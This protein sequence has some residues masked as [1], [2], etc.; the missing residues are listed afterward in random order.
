MSRVTKLFPKP[1][2]PANNVSF[3]SGIR[4][5]HSHESFSAGMSLMRC[6][7]AP[8]AAVCFPCIQQ[9]C[10]RNSRSSL[11]PNRDSCEPRS[12]FRLIYARVC[13]CDIENEGLH[14]IEQTLL[15]LGH[16]FIG[17]TSRSFI[18][19]APRRRTTPS[20]L[21]AAGSKPHDGCSGGAAFGEGLKRVSPGSS[22]NQEC[23][24]S[25]T[26]AV[27]VLDP[28]TTV[29][30]AQKPG[31]CTARRMP[32][33]REEVPQDRRPQPSKFQ[34]IRSLLCAEKAVYASRHSRSIRP[35]PQTMFP[36]TLWPTCLVFPR[37]A[38]TLHNR[39]L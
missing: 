23:R 36:Q 8:I 37:Q 25:P 26:S 19:G 39:S 12:D 33:S 17:G 20:R 9:K 1:G 3:P 10:L 27:Q 21:R 18:T 14:E 16:A 4:P 2:S 22:R 32:E 34:V 35:G 13:L 11:S 29:G 28:E 15:C 38:S 5:G 30:G 6:S 31:R 24:D 7:T